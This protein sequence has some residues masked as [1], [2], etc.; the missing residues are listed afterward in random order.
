MSAKLANH[1]GGWVRQEPDSRDL[2]FAHEE[3]RSPPGSFSLNAYGMLSP[4]V[5]DQ[6]QLGSCTAHGTGE[7]LVIARRRGVAAPFVPNW[8][9]PAR[10]FL[11]YNTRSLEGTVDEDA[12]AVIRDAV[13]AAKQWG[14]PHEAWCPYKIEDF[15]SKPSAKAYERAVKYEDIVYQSVDQSEAA[16]RT[17]VSSGLP[18]VFGFDVYESFES[19]EVALSGEMPMPKPGEQLLGGHCV[20][21]V[22]Y[23]PDGYEC[24]NSWGEGWGAGGYFTMP[25]DYLFSDRCSDFWVIDSDGASSG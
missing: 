13:K 9:R 1:H 7:L 4:H 23:S 5:W 12:G 6:G 25:A 24:R 3:L 20:C 19:E 11:Y 15:A 10:L 18:V 21:I 16:I 8:Q 17:A 2:R 14:V 22:G